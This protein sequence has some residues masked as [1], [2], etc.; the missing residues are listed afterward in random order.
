MATQEFV[1]KCED[2][3][4]ELSWRVSNIYANSVLM[5]VIVEQLHGLKIGETITE[6][7]LAILDVVSDQLKDHAGQSMG[8]LRF[9][10][11]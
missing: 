9:C 10:G 4:E 5:Q 11:F 7:Q 1:S 6:D 3:F 8:C 2:N